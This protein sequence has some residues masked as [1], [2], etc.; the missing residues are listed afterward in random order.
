MVIL[1]FIGVILM[2]IGV[3]LMFIGVILM[4]IG[5][6]LMFIVVILMFMGVILPE[7]CSY[8]A[9]RVRLYVSMI[10]V[11]PSSDRKS[12]QLYLEIM[13]KKNKKY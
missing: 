13:E 12:I 7:E 4:F 2:F 3:I 1:M 6:I 5:V 11:V 9:G 10:I 8:I